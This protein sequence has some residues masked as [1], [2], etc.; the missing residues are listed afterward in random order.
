MLC[1]ADG[2]GDIS[3]G[4]TVGEVFSLGEMLLLLKLCVS[5]GGGAGV[6]EDFVREGFEVSP[7]EVL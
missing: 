4:D 7:V 6:Y 3:E 5:G 1:A 2:R